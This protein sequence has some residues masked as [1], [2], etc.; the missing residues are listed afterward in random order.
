M[1]VVAPVLIVGLGLFTACSGESATSTTQTQSGVPPTSTS[2][3]TS[4]TVSTGETPSTPAAV[5]PATTT[6]I[7]PMDLPF[8]IDDSSEP[9]PVSEA[10]LISSDWIQLDS[11]PLTVR[12]SA[13]HAWT[14]DEIVIWGGE[15][16]GG[17]GAFGDGAAYNVATGEWRT[18]SDGPLPAATEAAWAWTGDELVIWSQMSFAAAWQPDTNTWRTI[19]DWPLIARGYGRAAWT[20][21]VILDANRG[22]LVDPD[23]GAA[24]AIA[25]PPGMQER[26]SVLWADGYLVAVTGDGSYDLQAD[27]WVDMPQSGLTPLATAGTWTGDEVVAVDYEMSASAYDPVTN[28]WT[29]Y[30][31]VPLRFFECFPRAYTLRGQPVAQHCSGIGAWDSGRQMWIPLAYPRPSIHSPDAFSTGERLFVWGRDGFYEL[32]PD[33]L[34]APARVVAGISLFDIHDDWS[35]VSTQANPTKLTLQHVSGDQ[36]TVTAIHAG[37]RGVLAQYLSPEPVVVEL[38]SYVGGNPYP[39][40]KIEPDN[41]D[42]RRHLVWATGTTD[43]VDVACVGEN[44]VEEVAQRIWT[45]YQNADS[46][47]D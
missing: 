34:D 20:G 28:T 22:L 25:D 39:A 5:P 29:P 36:C 16:L 37:A 32:K 46:D 26:A 8:E 17:G 43:V 30:P 1:R 38:V 19:E 47:G 40:L 18:L 23:T 6:S 31:D 9:R 44:D 33:A 27:I 24:R 4:T 21:E 42:Q 2:T 13:V 7:G 12:W 35:L 45:Q 14:G 41:V 15:R 10:V 11:G 3:T